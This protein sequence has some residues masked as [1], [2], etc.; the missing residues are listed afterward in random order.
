[1]TGR[2]E[3]KLIHIKALLDL[4]VIS[5]NLRQLFSTIKMYKIWSLLLLLNCIFNIDA[6]AKRGKGS[7]KNEYFNS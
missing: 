1:M 6:V 2:Y 3:P 5:Y 7:I 4:K